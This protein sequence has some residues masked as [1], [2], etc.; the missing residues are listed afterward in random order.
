M[1]NAKVITLAL[2]VTAGGLAGA[3]AQGAGPYYNVN[4]MDYPL[5]QRLTNSQRFA[6]T[7]GLPTLTSVVLESLAGGVLTDGGG[8]IAGSVYARV[9]FGGPY[10]PVTNY[11]AYNI[12]VTGT[13]STKNTNPLVKITLTGY[14]YDSDGVSNYPNAKLSLKFTS[15]NRLVRVPSTE[16]TVTNSNYSITYA[17]GST[18]L[19]TNG[20]LT[21]TNPAYTSLSGTMKGNISPGQN[22]SLN[23]GKQLKINEAGQL[24]TAGTNWTVVDGTHFV[25]H[26]LGDGLALDILTNIDAQVIQ[27][28][29]GSKLYLNAY[30][31]S[32]NELLLGSGTAN[33]NSNDLKWSASFTGVAFANG[34]KLQAKGYLGRLIVAYEPTT[35]TNNFPSG[36]FP[37]IVR[38]ALKDITITSGKLF[39][40]KVEPVGGFSVEATPPGP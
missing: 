38:N 2:L 29:P 19:F 32:V 9:Y 18:Q 21:K 17:D 40:Q 26:V 24:N 39:G 5:H 36:Y 8:H 25:E 22:S 16:V 13:T 7:T 31:G 35:D 12:T 33:T 1:K 34:S 15:T 14:G 4:A 23:N 20:P 37:R 11:G 10:R 28:L 3:A 27:P 6:V 30:V